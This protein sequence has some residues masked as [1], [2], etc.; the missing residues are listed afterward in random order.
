[1]PRIVFLFCLFSVSLVQAQLPIAAKVAPYQGKPSIFLNDTPVTPMIYAMTDSP[2]GRWSWEEY[3]QR[4][5]KQFTQAGFNLFMVSIWFQDIWRPD[6]RFNMDLVRRQMRGVLDANPN[7]AIIIRLH[8]NAPFWWNTANPDECTRYADG[9]WLR[10][11][12]YWEA[13][14]YIEEDIRRLKI[15]SLASEKWKTETTQKLTQFCQELSALSE[16]NAVVGI[17]PC[18]GVSHEWHYWG[19]IDHE[20]D[21]SQPMTV[22]FQNWLKTKYKTEAALRVAWNNP[23]AGFTTLTVPDTAERNH[24]TDGLFRD[25]AVGRRVMD[26]FEAQHQVVADDIIHFCRTIKEN[27]TRPILTGVFYG[28]YFMLFSRQVTGGHLKIDQVLRSPYV[29][30]LSAPQSYWGG[31]RNLGGSGQS[32]GLSAAARLHGKLF[33]DEMDDGT[34]LGHPYDKAW[35]STIPLDLIKLTRNTAQPLARGAGLW[36]YDFGPNFQG[37]WWDHPQ[38][39]QRITALKTLYDTHYA[40]PLNH[41]ADVLVVYDTD[42]YYAYKNRWNPL[43]ENSLDD[44]STD[45]YRSGAAFDEVYLSDLKGLDIGKYKVVV[46][47][48]TWRIDELTKAFIQKKVA[49]DGR[50]LVWNYL[51]GYT[52]GQRNDLAMVSQLTGIKVAPFALPTTPKITLTAPDWPAVSFALKKG[53]VQ[54]LAQLRDPKAATL[55]V[56]EGTNAVALTMKKEK[57]FTTYFCTLPLRAPE[58]WRAIFSR[59]GVHLYVETNDV[60]HAGGGLLT[61]HTKTGGPK[62]VRLGN[63]KSV[64]LNLPDG[65]ATVV[66]DAATGAVLMQ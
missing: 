59:A 34:A 39:M 52:N 27:W 57:T 37:G 23:A 19:F 20:P 36:Y 61:L 33:L 30:Y 24:F 63:G 5:L 51:P 47:A 28:Y 54:P 43:S 46:F 50:H 4:H 48:N 11:T 53:T 60:I 58:L 32:R 31:A 64:E 56:Y 44:F 41:P 14:R 6:G 66:L 3:P 12:T 9:P 65:A 62:H 25:P 2:G 15:H 40:A 22:Y 16:G 1:M 49:R 42:H 35:K 29:D 45:L 18:D 55:A 8:I 13:R 7:A 17:H 26:Y 10:D 21:T 38:L